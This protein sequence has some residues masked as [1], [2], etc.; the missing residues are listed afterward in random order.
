[1]TNIPEIERHSS[2][3]L[4]TMASIMNNGDNF[5]VHSLILK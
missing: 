2:I 3:W 1:M 5:K 4:K